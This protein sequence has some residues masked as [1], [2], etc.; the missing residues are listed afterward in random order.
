MAE[1]RLA[2]LEQAVLQLQID[3]KANRPVGPNV[4]DVT[5]GGGRYIGSPP[6]GQTGPSAV[7]QHPFMLVD[8][9]DMSGNN[10]QVVYG[11]LGGVVPDGMSP[12]DDP[13]YILT[14]VTGTGYVYLITTTD[15]DYL[16]T[17]VSI[18]FGATVPADDETTHTYY[19]QIGGFS[20]SGSTLSL[21][22]ALSGSQDFG[23]CNG[24]KYALV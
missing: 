15:D 1:G 7:T 2:A 6:V 13:P 21:S 5:G 18:D 24:A 20:V 11:T 10:I 14:G 3:V 16:I 22:Q 17:D 9:S 4:T 23:W 12:G 19:F 8:A